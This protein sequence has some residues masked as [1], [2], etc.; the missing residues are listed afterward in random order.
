MMS[1]D[2]LPNPDYARMPDRALCVELSKY[3]AVMKARRTDLITLEREASEARERGEAYA[4]I[5]EL[6]EKRIQFLHAVRQ[7]VRVREEQQKR[8]RTNHVSRAIKRGKAKRR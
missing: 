6:G 1:Y 4:K 8:G 5:G 3:D 2:S 7:C